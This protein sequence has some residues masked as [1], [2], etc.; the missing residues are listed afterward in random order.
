MLE[1]GLID[2]EVLLLSIK[3]ESVRSY[4]KEAISCYYAGTYRASILSIWIAL[5]LDLYKKSEYLNETFSDRAAKT[6][7]DEIERI[8]KS[9]GKASNW[10]DGILKKCYEDLKIINKL[11]YD[12]LNIIR[13][14]RNLCAHPVLDEEGMLYQPTAE[15]ARSHIV[16]AIN[17]VLNQNAILG[18]NFSEKIVEIIENSYLEDDKESIEKK[19]KFKYI[20]DSDE[21]L[22]KQLIKYILKLI[23]YCEIEKCELYSEKY[24]N[25]ILILYENKPQDFELIKEDL[26]QILEKTDA[27][28][29]QYII[30]LCYRVPFFGR[31]LTENIKQNLKQF[32]VD[33]GGNR[34]TYKIKLMPYIEEYVD[35]VFNYH[36]TYIS[37]VS[38][39]FLET[40]KKHNFENYEK[41]LIIKKRI[42]ENFVS[43]SR[44]HNASSSYRH[45]EEL[46]ELKLIDSKDIK[47][48]LEESPKNRGAFPFEENNQ[49]ISSEYCFIDL[50]K[51]SQDR[52]PEL[53]ENWEIFIDEAFK[54][55]MEFEELKSLIEKNS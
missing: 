36:L 1:K 15:E 35:E 31:I 10:E 8:R 29:L 45:I 4:A 12:K 25:T 47:L 9:N 2:L 18:K 19:L 30:G 55:Q 17:L 39:I 53:L 51:Y 33:L 54:N 21:N 16:N 23:T 26:I 6:L 32:I 3:N 37:K 24:L 11:Q 52:Y 43:A 27:D 14:D 5:V 44:W 7:I 22:R 42:L 28:H 13:Y 48:L 50:F 41:F 20:D 34:T 40:V 38:R 49:L 46:L